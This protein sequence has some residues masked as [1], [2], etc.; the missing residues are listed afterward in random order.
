MVQPEWSDEAIAEALRAAYEPD[1]TLCRAHGLLAAQ[2]A[3]RCLSR[4][5]PFV[6][7]ARMLSAV[8]LIATV[9]V[10]GCAL[11]WLDLRGMMSSPLLSMRLTL[12]AL[13]L[14]M[15]VL[16]TGT[17][18][19]L[20]RLDREITGRLFGNRWRSGPG[21]E[22]CAIRGLALGFSVLAVICLF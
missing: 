14:V 22:M 8:V 13:L 5:D 9:G 2:E 16:L 4:P 18:P 12:G 3:L 21:V 7:M 10:V 11:A 19:I 6:K 1:A 20:S 15:A 17:A